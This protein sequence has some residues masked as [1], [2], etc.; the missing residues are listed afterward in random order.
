MSFHAACEPSSTAVS[1]VD[2]FLYDVFLSFRGADTRHGFV[3]HLYNALRQ[4]GISTFKDDQN[5]DRGKPI[6]PEI[7]RKKRS[8]PA[9]L[10]LPAG[11]WRLREKGEAA[12]SGGF[13]WGVGGCG[14]EDGGGNKNRQRV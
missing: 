14:E 2:L 13:R 10:L 5:L 12:R 6:T 7:P 11:G 4:R 3:S 1:P 9:K 8:P